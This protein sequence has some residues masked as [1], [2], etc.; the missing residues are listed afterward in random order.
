MSSR[1]RTQDFGQRV[2]ESKV[3]VVVDFF[4]TWCGPCRLQ[5]P[6]LDELAGESEG[7]FDVVKVDVDQDPDLATKYGVT[8]LP[9]LLVFADGQVVSRYVGLT[10]KRPLQDALASA[11]H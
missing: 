2:L 10:Q 9:T 8:A 5:G 4:A 11:A 7:H 6:I 1:V 3:P